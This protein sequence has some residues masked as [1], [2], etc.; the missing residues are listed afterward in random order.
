M[1]VMGASG[2]VGSHLVPRLI[3]SGHEVYASARNAKVLNGRDWDIKLVSADALRPET[4]GPALDGIEVV[5]YLVHSMAAG[6]AFAALDREAAT[7]FRNAAGRANVRRI[8]Y[9]GGLQPPGV[10][11]EH[12]RSRRETGEILRAGTVPVTELRAGIVVG[13]G[14]AAFEVIR[15]LVY[16]LPVMVTPRWVQSRT[17][18][19]ALDD[20]LDY[21][22]RLPQVKETAGRT[23]DVGGPETLSYE[24]MLRGFAEVVERNLKI[25]RVPVLSPRLS[26]YWLDFVTAVPASVAR[27]LVDGLRHDLL[28]DTADIQELIPLELRGYVKAVRAA[29]AGERAQKLPARWTEGALPFRAGRPDISFYSKGVRTEDSCA[30]PAAALWASV[31]RI[32]GDEGW[33]GDLLWRLRGAVDRLLGGV[34]MRRGRRNPT[35]LRVGDSLDFWRVVAIEPGR[36][37]TLL[38]EMKLPGTA[39]LEFTVQ[40]AA[41][42]GSTLRTDARFHPAGTLGLLYWYGLTPIHGA[43]FAGQTRRLCER[44]ER[45]VRPDGNTLVS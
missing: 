15:D 7:N 20:L 16:H 17:Q 9:L 4:L 40:D 39:V 10:S 30:A 22:V 11:S 42:S 44:A 33:Y 27:P 45:S 28:A 31:I 13:P 12:L 32:G 23:F 14:S 29:L 1:L 43:I 36:R 24:E 34:G 8:I 25:V 37:L 35:E 38:A 21:L 5:Y 3:E 18:P 6:R 2:Y 41:G 26:S 19:I